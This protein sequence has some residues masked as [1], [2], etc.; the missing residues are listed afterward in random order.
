MINRSSPSYFCFPVA[1]RSRQQRKGGGRPFFPLALISISS[2]G[3]SLFIVA[4]SISSSSYRWVRT[5]EGRRK[6]ARRLGRRGK[7]EAK[8]SRRVLLL[9]PLLH[10]RVHGSGKEDGSCLEVM[11]PLYG[12]FPC[13]LFQRLRHGLDGSSDI[14]SSHNRAKATTKNGKVR[15]WKQSDIVNLQPGFWHNIP[16]VYWVL[17]EISCRLGLPML[18]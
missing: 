1:D 14:A 8:K 5:G 12:F 9:L 18:S 2:F 6:P 10:L 7:K 17:F 11:P 13:P 15:N 4:R 16:Y 3:R